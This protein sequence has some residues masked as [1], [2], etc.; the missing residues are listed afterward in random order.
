MRVFS[1]VP[2]GK[3]NFSNKNWHLVLFN[4]WIDTKIKAT[5]I[6]QKWT[7]SLFYEKEDRTLSLMKNWG[8]LNQLDDYNETAYYFKCWRFFNRYLYKK[9]FLNKDGKWELYP[10]YIL[11]DYVTNCLYLKENQQVFKPS[12]K[13]YKGT[14]KLHLRPTVTAERCWYGFTFL[15]KW[16]LWLGCTRKETIWIDFNTEL[17][18]DSGSWKGGIVATSYPYKTSLINS[19]LNFR[20]YELSKYIKEEV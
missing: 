10:E 2:Y 5:K 8:N 7:T 19:W 16:L 15:P 3:D 1:F 20:D 11:N 14:K 4:W 18:K 9:E 17:G 12:Y 13:Y 6:S